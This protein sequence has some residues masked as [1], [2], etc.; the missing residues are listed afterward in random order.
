MNNQNGS[1]SLTESVIGRALDTLMSPCSTSTARQ[2]S[3][4][5]LEEVILAVMQSRSEYSNLAAGDTSARPSQVKVKGKQKDTHDVRH[6]W[7][8]LQDSPR[9]NVAHAL[10]AHIR[11][12]LSAM[13]APPGFYGASEG[14]KEFVP[15]SQVPTDMLQELLSCFRLLPGLCLTHI[16]SKQL[17]AQRG[18]IDL[19]LTLAR[20]LVAIA[21]TNAASNHNAACDEERLP[22]QQLLTSIAAALTAILIDDERAAEEFEQRGG[23]ETLKDMMSISSEPRGVLSTSVASSSANTLIQSR[24]APTKRFEPSRAASDG[25]KEK[26]RRSEADPLHWACLE[27][28]TSLYRPEEFEAISKRESPRK[29]RRR[30]MGGASSRD[31]S[32]EERKAAQIQGLDQP[33]ALSIRDQPRV[34]KVPSTSSLFDTDARA[35]GPSTRRITSD[36]TATSRMLQV[37]S[38]SILRRGRSLQAMRPDS[39]AAPSRLGEATQAT[40]RLRQV[41][42]S[43]ALT[44]SKT[45]RKVFTDPEKKVIKDKR[46]SYTALGL[47]G[48]RIAQNGATAP[49]TEIRRSARLSNGASET[50]SRPA[51]AEPVSVSRGNRPKE[52][53]TVTPVFAQALTDFQSKDVPMSPAVKRAHAVRSLPYNK[54][55]QR[56]DLLL[57]QRFKDEPSAMHATHPPGRRAALMSLNGHRSGHSSQ[58]S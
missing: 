58:A 55:K 4:R 20:V 10:V 39:S 2:A 1:K 24:A 40:P 17:C 3:L 43:L 50:E 22:M 44:S 6:V 53:R 36:H 57:S 5:R 26:G 41:A 42:S 27:L 29:R 46:A 30:N 9:L 28:L 32:P 38:A 33:A 21:A 25:S 52:T 47:G 54:S 23:L 49:A 13:T 45:A 7:C 56:L 15:P 16:A 31:I 34:R 8:T 48:G 37:E 11:C 35:S 18:V 12:L 14:M 51:F 19:C